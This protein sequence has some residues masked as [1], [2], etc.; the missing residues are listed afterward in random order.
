MS[1]GCL[2]LNGIK[3]VLKDNLVVPYEGFPHDYGCVCIILKVQEL[4]NSTWRRTQ[5]NATD[6][7]HSN[8][9]ID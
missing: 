3:S 1:K 2:F 9:M 6:L 5:Y 7:V 4:V 8:L